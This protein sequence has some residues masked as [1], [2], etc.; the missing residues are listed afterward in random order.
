MFKNIHKIALGTFAFSLALLGACD[1]NDCPE[2]VRPEPFKLSQA[3][4]DRFPY[5]ELNTLTFL[6]EGVKETE[7]ITLNKVES[8][9]RYV[10]YKHAQD[11]DGSCP[12]QISSIDENHYVIFEAENG[13]L[14]K[15]LTFKNKR[16]S[17]DISVLFGDHDS[18]SITH[19]YLDQLIGEENEIP[20]TETVELRDTTYV[21]AKRRFF[22]TPEPSNYVFQIGTGFVH[23]V[24]TKNRHTWTLVEAK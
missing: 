9:K 18:T 16:S 7:T 24:D 4:Q 21:G 10:Y 3:Q 23:M 20:F 5:T 2:V 13:D 22:E 11:H 12:R 15:T 14:S 1:R 6:V 19:G 17:T 8:G